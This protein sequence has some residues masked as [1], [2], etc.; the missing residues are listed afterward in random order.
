MR[1]IFWSKLRDSKKRK[2]INAMF[3]M[4]SKTYDAAIFPLP[5]ESLSESMAHVI[6]IEVE[7]I[8]RL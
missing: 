4:V 1:S 2:T 8:E 5:T 3:G 6:T 7:R